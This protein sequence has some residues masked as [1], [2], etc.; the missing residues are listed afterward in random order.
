M[1][2]GF[3]LQK[4]PRDADLIE[5]ILKIANNKGTIKN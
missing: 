2:T 4:N 1:P 3:F 5:D